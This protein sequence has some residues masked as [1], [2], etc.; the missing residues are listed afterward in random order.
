L[1]LSKLIGDRFNRTL[2]FYLNKMIKLNKQ[3]SVFWIWFGFASLLVVKLTYIHF[4]NLISANLDHIIKVHYS[5]MNNNINMDN[6]TVVFESIE[7]A[8]FNLEIMYYMSL[9]IILC[10]IIVLWSKFH[11]KVNVELHTYFVLGMRINNK[12]E[13]YLNK[14]TSY[15]KDMSP[16][17]ILLLVVLLIVTLAYSAYIWNE[18]YVNIDY[19]VYIYMHS[20]VT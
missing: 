11:L 14:I 15:F 7:D 3:M 8:L 13:Y 18:L 1:G 12:L 16:I 10:L 6:V 4:V 19:Y 17:Y 5:F 2:E 20:N 9:I